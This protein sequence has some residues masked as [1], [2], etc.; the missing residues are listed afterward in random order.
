MGDLEWCERQQTHQ[1]SSEAKGRWEETSFFWSLQ[2]DCHGH[3]VSVSR[4]DYPNGCYLSFWL[5]EERGKYSFWYRLKEAWWWILGKGE[6]SNEVVIT[7]VEA[8]KLHEL[9]RDSGWKVTRDA[10]S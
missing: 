4:D 2:C 7:G 8:A 3:S 1:M 10:Q 9:T 6:N 5:S